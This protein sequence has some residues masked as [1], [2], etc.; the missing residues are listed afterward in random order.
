M[1]KKNETL[2]DT[3][4]DE[5]RTVLRIKREE[6]RARHMDFAERNDS[7][8]EP[9]PTRVRLRKGTPAFKSPSR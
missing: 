9:D 4:R 8:F 2:T 7:D 3:Q 5:L 1:A 6:I